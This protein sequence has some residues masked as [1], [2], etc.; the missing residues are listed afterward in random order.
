MGCSGYTFHCVNLDDST[1]HALFFCNVVA[2]IFYLI[3]GR[4]INVDMVQERCKLLKK[5]T[6]EKKVKKTPPP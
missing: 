6:S 2:S 4:V 3:E 5:Y 1:M